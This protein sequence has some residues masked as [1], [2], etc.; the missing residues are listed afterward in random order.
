MLLL[1]HAL[2]MI[3]LWSSATCDFQYLDFE[4]IIGL[5]LRGSAST[6][7]CDAGKRLSYRTDKYGNK[8]HGNMDDSTLGILPTTQEDDNFAQFQEV[9]TDTLEGSAK[10][11]T[12]TAVLGHRDKYAFAPGDMRVFRFDLCSSQPL[13]QMFAH[14]DASGR[15]S[16]HK[17]DLQTDPS[18]REDY[19]ASLCMAT[20]SSKSTPP[21]R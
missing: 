9:E 3:L 1:L 2:V 16:H 17:I 5:D 19:E 8:T 11:S 6:T 15:Y 7:S 20:C 14:D 13:H 18:H 12:E 4:S 21:E 10:V